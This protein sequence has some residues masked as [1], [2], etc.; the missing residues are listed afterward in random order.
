MVRS[1]AQL[2]PYQNIAMPSCNI[3]TTER[4]VTGAAGLAL[5]SLAIAHVVRNRRAWSGA[6]TTEPHGDHRTAAALGLAAGGTLLARAAS[7]FCPVYALLG[8][9]SEDAEWRAKTDSPT[10]RALSGNRGFRLRQTITIGRP[11]QDVYSFWRQFENLPRF[12]QHLQSVYTVDARRSH[13]VAR[14]PAGTN[15]EWDAEIVHEEPGKVIG[16]QTLD[17]ADVASAGSVNFDPAPDGR[18]TLVTVSLQYQPPAGAIGAAVARLFGQS[19]SQQIH[20]D[21]G[22]LKE[23]LETSR[24]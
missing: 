22:R 5:A 13:W 24:Q 7:G 11:P 3:S 8:K 16:W 23:L 18:G 10:T 14:G 2:V 17:N 20:E 19:P 15:V 21:L 1:L 6:S 4:W 9:G 12:M